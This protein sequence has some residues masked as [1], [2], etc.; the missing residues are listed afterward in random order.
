MTSSFKPLK[1]LFVA[2]ATAVTLNLALAVEVEGTRFDENVKVANADLVLNG[3]GVRS[4]FGKRYVAALY[5][6]EKSSNANA[7]LAA[8]GP[9]RIALHL[10]KDADGH[11]FAK[12]F[13]SAIEDNT[14][15]GDMASIQDR[16][17][18]LAEIMQGMGEVKAGSVVLIDWVPG[19]GTQVTV[20]GKV[21]GKEIPGEDFRKALFRVWLGENPVQDD[22]KAGLLSRS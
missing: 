1:P 10:L 16:V 21:Q 4:K 20:N 9:Q 5:V 15:A 22:L 7:I 13:S 6:G 8:R 19:K 12:A 14:S 17:K 3:T 2:V 11:T 18:L